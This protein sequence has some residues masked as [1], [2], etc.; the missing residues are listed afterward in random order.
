[1]RCTVPQ[2]DKSA[3]G[4]TKRG[5]A[6]RGGQYGTREQRRP[7]R[8]RYG[9][10]GLFGRSSFGVIPGPRRPVAQWVAAHEGIIRG[11]GRVMS[12][13]GLWPGGEDWEPDVGSLLGG[14][15]VGVVIVGAVW[16]LA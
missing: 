12:D 9:A 8:T 4:W 5:R 2:S 13:R 7:R 1:M 3:R 16:L 14:I 10:L 11:R 15:V 6:E